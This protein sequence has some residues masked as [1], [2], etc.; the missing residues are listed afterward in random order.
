MAIEHWDAVPLPLAP[1]DLP[2]DLTRTQLREQLRD[3]STAVV[4][5]HRLAGQ[6]AALHEQGRRVRGHEDGSVHAMRIAARRLRSALT[7]FGPVLEGGTPDGVRDELRWLGQELSPARDAQVLRER[8]LAMLEA[9]PPELVLGPVASRIDD[10]LRGAERRGRERALRALE[11]ERSARLL[12][13]LDQLVLEPPLGARAQE[14]A[15]DLLPDLLRRDLERLRRA[16]EAA[17]EREGQ[18]R[19]LALHE[20]RKKAKRLRYAAEAAAPVL[21][22]RADKL[23]RRATA[24][25][26]SLGEHQDSVV[27]R[28]LLREYGAQAH[29]EAENG[30]TFGRLHALEEARGEAAV[31]D[32]E[33]AW[34]RI[35]TKSWV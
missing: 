19:D 1:A 15:R 29:G 10:G 33:K 9:Q 14:P 7:T 3:A 27:S 31:R 32:F 22:K 20:A 12:D 2:G 13:A 23:V 11:D 35:R 5:R 24:V 30:F 8:L 21:G 26:R 16:V 28:A 6:L 17:E 18:D 25:Q 34:R 4:L